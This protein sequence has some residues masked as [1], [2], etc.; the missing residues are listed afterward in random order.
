MAVEAAAGEAIVLVGG[1][2][3]RLRPLVSD[4]P[5]PLAPVAGRPFLAWVLEHLAEAG[6]RRAILATGYMAGAVQSAIGTEWHGMAVDYS[7]EDAPLGTGGAVRKARAMLRGDGVHVLNGDTFLRY[8]PAALA[9]ATIRN[10]AGIGV[11][12]AEVDDVSR[13]GAVERDG[14]TIVRFSEKGRHG[15]GWINAGCYFLPLGTLAA[16]PDADAFSLEAEVVAP[17][18]AAG[19]AIGYDGTRGFIDIG[20]PEDYQRAQSLF[21][22]QA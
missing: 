1:L 13:Y 19:R 9:A 15:A 21:G 20:V 6:V 2:G 14:D 5:K 4:V 17:L 3:T 11:A 22:G 8:S 12:L 16:L 10:G 18:A 7:I